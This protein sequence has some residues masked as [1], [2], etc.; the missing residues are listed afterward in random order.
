MVPRIAG[1]QGGR[2]ESAEGATCQGWEVLGW[3]MTG[4]YANWPS[5]HKNQPVFTYIIT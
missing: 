3:E 1:S 4:V 5:K 2:C